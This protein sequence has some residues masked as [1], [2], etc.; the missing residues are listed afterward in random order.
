ML[1]C[2]DRWG[3]WCPPL[4]ACLVGALSAC[5]AQPQPAAEDVARAVQLRPAAPALAE[6]YERSC[7]VC[8]SQVGAQAPLTGFAPDWQPR[9]RQGMGRLL[10]H[11]QQ[12][13]NAMPAG[14]QCADCSPEELRALI[15]F[16]VKGTAS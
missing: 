14:G 12:G 1:F 2:F 13:L 6:K 5:S 4:L 9:L 10:Q 15:E 8:H 11:A 7:M 3:L 16:M